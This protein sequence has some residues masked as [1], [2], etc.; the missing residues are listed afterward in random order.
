MDLHT[1]QFLQTHSSVPICEAVIGMPTKGVWPTDLFR[2]ALF[3][4]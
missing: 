3:L 4:Y 2:N 1:G